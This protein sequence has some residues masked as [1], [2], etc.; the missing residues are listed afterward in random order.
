MLGSSLQDFW[1][2]ARRSEAL[3]RLES[4]RQASLF[5]EEAEE[6]VVP[7]IRIK[8]DVSATTKT[9]SLKGKQKKIKPFGEKKP[10]AKQ[11]PK[12]KPAKQPKARHYSKLKVLCEICS[13]PFEVSPS[14][15]KHQHTCGNKE[16]TSR[17]RSLRQQARNKDRATP[18][19][20]K[21]PEC[22]N[23]LNPDKVNHHQKLYC[24]I[25]CAAR[26]RAMIK[27]PCISHA[28]GLLD[29]L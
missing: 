19:Q 21:H 10:V 1:A 5:A 3:E 29:A 7:L 16:C 17:L 4:K 6:E 28:I 24:S 22:Q 26:H 9:A 25:R 18:K 27:K 23:F 8:K 12:S 11:E 14:R 15:A 2:E 20:C 13:T